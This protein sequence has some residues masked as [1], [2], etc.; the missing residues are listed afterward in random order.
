MKDRLNY[1]I[2]LGQVGLRYFTLANSRQRQLRC[3]SRE[4]V[5]VTRVKFF[6]F[7][8]LQQ[9]QVTHSGI[10]IC[11]SFRSD[12]E[13]STV[14]KNNSQSII[15]KKRTGNLSLYVGVVVCCFILA[16]IR[17]VVLFHILINSSRNLHNK[18]F[19]AILR[20]P[21]YFFDTNPVGR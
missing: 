21:I 20:A 14:A 18:M 11:Q 7:E 10:L 6:H 8:G 15:E 5:K 1:Q 4:R 13:E 17:A 9:Y 12:W 3:L 2:F 19:K 16:F